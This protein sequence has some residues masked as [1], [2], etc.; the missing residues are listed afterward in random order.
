MFELRGNPERQLRQLADDL[1]AADATIRREIYRGLQS[2]TKDLRRQLAESA[3]TH[4]PKGGGRGVAHH[5]RAGRRIGLRT[6][7][8]ASRAGG[9][10]GVVE[11]LAQRVHNASY[12]TRIKSTRKQT[13]ITIVVRAKSGRPVDVDLA[14]RGTVRHPT[15][16]HRPSVT[17]RVR[18][19]W[20][21]DEFKKQRKTVRKV[22]LKAFDEA[23][24]KLRESN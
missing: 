19:G 17:Q 5:N 23:K 21:D 14:D 6:S 7:G 4:L 20:F 1:R 8:R 24:R 18:S 12:L 2:E 11:S 3:L 13:R 16:G 10:R 22:L 9:V 15:F